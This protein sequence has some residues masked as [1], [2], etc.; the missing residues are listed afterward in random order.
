MSNGGGSVPVRSTKNP[1]LGRP[2][3]WAF[4]GRDVRSRNV[5]RATGVQRDHVDRGS[6]RVHR[7]LSLPQ[8]P[9][10]R[11]RHPTGSRSDTWQ[12]LARAGLTRRRRERC[13]PRRPPRP[14]RRSLSKSGRPAGLAAPP[15]HPDDKVARPP[16]PLRQRSP[17]F[18]R[19]RTPKGSRRSHPT[20]THT[21]TGALL[22]FLERTGMGGAP[23]AKPQ[24]ARRCIGEGR[25]SN[26]YRQG[27][28]RACRPAVAHSSPCQECLKTPAFRPR[29]SG[30]PAGNLRG[31]R[32][33]RARSCVGAPCR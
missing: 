29:D 3:A 25:R 23:H 6:K 21:S 19:S 5:F 8:A 7:G 2:S 20:D 22:T 26:P 32:Q 1:S 30:N 24:P 28:D 17:R 14:A 13:H 4:A 31:R 15:A 16:H 27:R 10:R 9:C 11:P 33:A 18:H 12:A